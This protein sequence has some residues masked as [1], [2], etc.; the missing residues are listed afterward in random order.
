MAEDRSGAALVEY[1]ILIGLITVAA[2]ATIKL[3]GTWVANEWIS[4]KTT[5]GA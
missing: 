4:L 2:V 1:S 5:I 3:V